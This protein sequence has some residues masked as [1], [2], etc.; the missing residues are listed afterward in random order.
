MYKEMREYEGNPRQFV[1]VAI[2]DDGIGI[3]EENRKHLFEP[4]F[5]TKKTK[6]DVPEHTKAQGLG[7]GLAYCKSIITQHEGFLTYE[8]EL[9]VFTEFFIYLPYPNQ[10]KDDTDEDDG[11]VF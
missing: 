3:D 1:V 7:L 11:V 10:N 5:S 4:F 8:S 6:V 2:R 9:N